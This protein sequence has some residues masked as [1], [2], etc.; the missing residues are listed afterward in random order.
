MLFW[1]PELKVAPVGMEQ[2]LRLRDQSEVPK[3]RT[4]FDWPA[5]IR[6]A[7]DVVETG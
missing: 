4:L 2:S 3:H 1:R 6:V 7:W 5:P